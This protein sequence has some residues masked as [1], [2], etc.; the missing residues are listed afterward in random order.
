MTGERAHPVRTLAL[1]RVIFAALGQI[2]TAAIYRYCASYLEKLRKIVDKSV[3]GPGQASSP[4]GSLIV[5]IGDIS[6][7]F[8]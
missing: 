8:K 5:V 3:F 6:E 1:H 4:R 7:R 2:G